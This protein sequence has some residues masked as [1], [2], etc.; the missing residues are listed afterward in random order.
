MP[1]HDHYFGAY[2]SLKLTRDTNGCASPNSHP[3]QNNL[4]FGI[5]PRAHLITTRELN[6]KSPRGS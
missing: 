6:S 5:F 4:I 3:R 1:L 2:R